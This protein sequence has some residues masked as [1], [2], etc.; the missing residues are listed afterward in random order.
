MAIRRSNVFVIGDL[1]I[2]HSVF[3][4]APKQQRLE[5]FT[6][7][8]PFQVI[9]RL[10]TAGGAATTARTINMLPEG[11]TFLWGL[12][13]NSPWG[14][15]RTILENSQALDGGTRRIEFR[16]SRDETDA[17][18]TTVSHL[19]LTTQEPNRRERY[20]RKARFVDLGKSM[21]RPRK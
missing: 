10:D 17:P 9:R 5:P 2:D 16:G 14:S 7:E 1:A 4:S 8:E 19:I 3:V 20:L 13:G 18:M 21:L 11:T 6:G 12:I 15:F